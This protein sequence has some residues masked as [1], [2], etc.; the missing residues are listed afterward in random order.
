MKFVAERSCVALHTPQYLWNSPQL[1]ES[2]WPLLYSQSWFF[3]ICALFSAEGATQLGIWVMEY[4]Y[5]LIQCRFNL[6]ILVQIMG[7]KLSTSLQ[8]FQVH[9][10]HHL[11]V[12]PPQMSN[13]HPEWPKLAHLN[14]EE[15]PLCC[16]CSKGV[17][18]FF[19]LPKAASSHPPP[20]LVVGKARKTSGHNLT[21]GIS[22]SACAAAWRKQ[23]IFFY[24]ERGGFCTVY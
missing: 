10:I 22:V 5:G 9:V 3:C 16:Q 11:H 15:Q 2:L 4:E 21:P 6:L 7:E 12:K 18:C 24:Y 17:L 20:N 14:T 8:P 1:Q 23:A 19:P 13:T